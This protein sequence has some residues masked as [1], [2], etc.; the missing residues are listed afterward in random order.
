[1]K[2]LESQITS[3]GQ[4]SVPAPIRRKLGLAPGSKVEWCEKGNDVI[5][6]RASKYSSKEIHDAVFPDNAQRHDYDAL[7]GGIRTHIR[8]KHARD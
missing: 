1:M 8:N 6:R 4:I 7:K 2:T 5:V 3:Q